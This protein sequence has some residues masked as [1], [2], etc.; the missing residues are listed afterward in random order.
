MINYSWITTQPIIP[1]VFSAHIICLPQQSS[2]CVCLFSSFWCSLNTHVHTHMQNE[3]SSVRCTGLG[4]PPGDAAPPHRV[5]HDDA[6]VSWDVAT[7]SLCHDYST[8][9]SPSSHILTLCVTACLC[10]SSYTSHCIWPR[11]LRHILHFVSAALEAACSQK[12]PT[13]GEKK[14]ALEPADVPLCSHRYIKRSVMQ[15][16]SLT[17]LINASIIN[18][19][20]WEYLSS[21]DISWI[22]IKL[23]Y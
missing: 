1:S 2:I 13:G 3:E 17:E 15:M 10:L 16:K 19:S 11:W 12:L 14:E 21:Y 18:I 7:L 5:L 8:R 22:G 4:L 9:F 23:E 6:R 20:V